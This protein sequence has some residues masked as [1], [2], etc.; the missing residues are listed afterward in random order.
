MLQCNEFV[1][2]VGYIE[3]DF[4]QTK[5]FRKKCE[6]NRLRNEKTDEKTGAKDFSSSQRIQRM[7]IRKCYSETNTAQI[8]VSHS[9]SG[10]K[11]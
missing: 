7:R 8:K 4:A 3:K 1:T 11:Y 6:R 5:D 10:E 9:L 2:R